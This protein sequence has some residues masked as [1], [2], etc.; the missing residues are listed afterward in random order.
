MLRQQH[1][2]EFRNTLLK[3]HT[4]THALK[5]WG[6]RR[7]PSCHRFSSSSSS[8]VPRSE[9]IRAQ[10][11]KAPVPVQPG[12]SDAGIDLAKKTPNHKRIFKKHLQ[13]YFEAGSFLPVQLVVLLHRRSLLQNGGAKRGSPAGIVGLPSRSRQVGSGASRP[14]VVPGWVLLLLLLL[15]PRSIVVSP[16]RLQVQLAKLAEDKLIP[17]SVSMLHH[18]FR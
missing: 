7:Q 12:E 11:R 14:R 13:G 1:S 8:S 5:W 16:C 18:I 3:L 9:R 4:Q 17:L 15:L 10:G 6:N 2:T